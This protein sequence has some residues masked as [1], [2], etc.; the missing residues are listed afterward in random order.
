MKKK[1]TFFRKNERPNFY[2]MLQKQ[3]EITSRSSALFVQLLDCREEMLAKEIENCEKKADQ[4][5]RELIDYVENS[6]ITPLDRHDLFAVSRAI[7]D[8]TDKIK[9]LKDFLLF[10]KFSPTEKHK[11]MG[12]LIDASIDHI[13]GAMTEWAG[14]NIDCFWDDLVK[15]KKNENQI[16]RIY[17]ENIRDLEREKLNLKEIITM[18]EFSKD[19]NSLANKVGKAADYISD[20]K[21]KSI[22]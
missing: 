14:D 1:K 6:F 13:T 21:I 11:E 4:V 8:I 3:C 2:T 9:D 10:F 12:K 17:W 5:R 22:K 7:D 19:L 20:I 15:A 18:Q 16:K